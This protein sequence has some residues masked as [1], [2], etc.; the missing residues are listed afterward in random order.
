MIQ[1]SIVAWWKLLQSAAQQTSAYHRRQQYG[2]K[3][4][5]VWELFQYTLFIFLYKLPL[6]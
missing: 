2:E 1:W 4:S 5:Y 3:E 6:L